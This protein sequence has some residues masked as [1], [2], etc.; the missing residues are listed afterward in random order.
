MEQLGDVFKMGLGYLLSPMMISGAAALKPWSEW[1]HGRVALEDVSINYRYAGSG[2]P[3]LLVH[4]TPQYSLVWQ[5]MGPILAENYTVIAP[6]NRGCGDS[7]IPSS[8]NYSATAS[9]A[10]LKGLLDFF[11]ITSTYVFS[12]DKGVGPATALAV[13]HPGLVKRLGVS[14]FLYPGSGYEANSAPAPFVDVYG[15]SQLSFL[16][17]A[18]LAELFL[19]DREKQFVE[20]YYYHGSYSSPQSISEDTVNQYATSLRKPGSLRALF[21]PFSGGSIAAD[22]SFFAG[23]LGASL[24][25]SALLEQVFGP[26]FSDLELDIVPQAGHWIGDENPSWTANRVVQFLA[27]DNTP[28]PTIDLL[29]PKSRVILKVGLYGTSRNAELAG[30]KVNSR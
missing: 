10:G 18:D 29:D 8:G 5:W 1:E 12:H 30:F 23:T 19:R 24:G 6:D 13:Q 26:L 21:G 4:G 17:I 9:A 20:W 28:L 16:Y 15:N 3:L 14:E 7:S 11:N 22:N 2:P 27:N 25:I